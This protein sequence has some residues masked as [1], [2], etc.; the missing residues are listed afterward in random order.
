MSHAHLLLA[1]ALIAASCG[2]GKGDQPEPTRVVPETTTS[3]METTTTAALTTVTTA[4]QTTTTTSTTSTTTSTLPEPTEAE[5]YAVHCAQCHGVELEG[6]VGP[7]L[8]PDGH[9]HGHA[10]A[11]LVDIVTNGKNIMPAFGEKLTP[12][13]ITALID[14]IKNAETGG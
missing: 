2:G 3:T 14:F 7:A 8:G 11:E 13:Q 1:F 9:A 6:G 4:T 12:E 5:L 10:D